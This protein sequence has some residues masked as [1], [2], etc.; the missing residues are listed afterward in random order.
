MLVQRDISCLISTIATSDSR[1]V[2]GRAHATSANC[3]HSARSLTALREVR[4]ACTCRL[5]AVRL[6]REELQQVAVIQLVRPLDVRQLLA[7]VLERRVD[8]AELDVRVNRLA[9][10]ASVTKMTTERPLSA[11]DST[12]LSAPG[13]PFT[14][15]CTAG[16]RMVSAR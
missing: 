6:D 14:T 4:R 16:M 15:S 3:D 2:A 1:T 13:P 12:A 11:A 8:E 10:A 9:R 7:K 5:A